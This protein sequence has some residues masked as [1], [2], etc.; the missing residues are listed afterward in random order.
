MLIGILA[1]LRALTLKGPFKGAI[2]LIGVL[3]I[4]GFGLAMMGNAVAGNKKATSSYKK[5]L[6]SLLGKILVGICRGLCQLAKFIFWTAPSFIYK[7]LLESLKNKKVFV[8]YLVAI[9]G[10]LATVIILI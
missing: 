5:G 9:L 10:Y 8:R 3:L 2:T 4:M 1:L 6:S 7:K